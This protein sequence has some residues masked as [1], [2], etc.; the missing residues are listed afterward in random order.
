MS[1]GFGM[2]EFLRDLNDEAYYRKCEAAIGDAIKNGKKSVFL[3]L[4]WWKSGMRQL[5]TNPMTSY[6]LF[7]PENGRLAERALA[8]LNRC[9][10][11]FSN[12][13]SL[14]FGGVDGG[15]SCVIR[16]KKQTE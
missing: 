15:S 13:A 10:K 8:V 7:N 3:D 12:T 2:E 9:S 4:D 16:P 14:H 5:G 6:V 11:H 1:G